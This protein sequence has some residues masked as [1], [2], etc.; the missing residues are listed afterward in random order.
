M[1]ILVAGAGAVG[2]AVGGSLALAGHPVGF[3]ARP[4]YVHQ[5][6]ERGLIL[7]RDGC[8]Q[9]IPDVLADTEAGTLVAA[10]GGLDLAMVTTK[11]YDTAEVCR[12]LRGPVHDYGATVLVIQNGLGGDAIAAGVLGDTPIVTV[13]T[14]QVMTPA[15]M[16]VSPSTPAAMASPPTPFCITSTVAP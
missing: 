2:S 8:P 11:V 3:L 6:R 4:T 7:T 13:D 16:G 1:R 10:L 9:R 5:V 12:G 14:T 15:T